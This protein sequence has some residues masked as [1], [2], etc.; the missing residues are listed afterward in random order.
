[1]TAGDVVFSAVLWFVCGVIWGFNLGFWLAR[2]KR[3]GK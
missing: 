2:R 3:E 1:M